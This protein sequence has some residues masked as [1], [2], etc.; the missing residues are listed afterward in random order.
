MC[1]HICA[2][3]SCLAAPQPSCY[4]THG[5][6]LPLLPLAQLANYKALT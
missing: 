1:V 6:L 4:A 5:A 2:P 3:S